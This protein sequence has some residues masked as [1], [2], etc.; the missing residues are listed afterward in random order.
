[1]TFG[2]AADSATV[3]IRNVPGLAER[4]AVVLHP[5]VDAAAPI[6]SRHQDGV[7][8]LA[9]PLVRGCAMVKLTK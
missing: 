7:L 6:V 1:V 2:G 4:K 3:Q 5:G 8:T 9:V